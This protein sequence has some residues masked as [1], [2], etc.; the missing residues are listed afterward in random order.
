MALSSATNF[1]EKDKTRAKKQNISKINHRKYD[2][3]CIEWGFSCT[4]D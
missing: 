2:E 3:A 4:P 1:V